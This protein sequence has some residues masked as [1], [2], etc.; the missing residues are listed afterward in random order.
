MWTYEKQNL[1]LFGKLP[2]GSLSNTFRVTIVFRSATD[3]FSCTIL[4]FSFRPWSSQQGVYPRHLCTVQWFSQNSDQ[5]CKNY[6]YIV[7]GNFLNCNSK[8]VCLF[9]FLFYHSLVGFFCQNLFPGF[10]P[11]PNNPSSMSSA[12]FPHLCFWAVM[13]LG[14]SL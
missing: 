1:L 11:I 3:K 10:L 12:S 13:P 14:K 4:L 6:P 5:A 2:F 9:P 7:N 8:E